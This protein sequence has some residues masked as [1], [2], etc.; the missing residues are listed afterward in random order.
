MPMTNEDDNKMD[1]A[2]EKAK[3]EMMPS[4][5]RA[6]PTKEVTISEKVTKLELA[7]NQIRQD[8]EKQRRQ[9]INRY[10]QRITDIK[11]DYET[12]IETETARLTT[13]WNEDVR[14]LEEEYQRELNDLTLLLARMG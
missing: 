13:A 12:R 3:E 14:S 4:Q 9:L 11:N 10:R 7:H 1:A 6:V 8:I 2:V 5:L